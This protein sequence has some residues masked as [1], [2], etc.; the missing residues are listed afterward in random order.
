MAASPLGPGA[1]ASDVGD[2]AALATGAGADAP[3]FFFVGAVAGALVGFLTGAGASATGTGGGEATGASTVGGVAAGGVAT[4]GA[5]AGAAVVG[6]SVAGVV[7]P[8][9][10]GAG[11]AGDNDVGGSTAGVVDVDG[12][13]AGAVEAPV[14]GAGV[15]VGVAAGAAV[16]GLEEDLGGAAAG[17]VCAAALVDI[18]RQRSAAQRTA[19]RAIASGCA[20]PGRG[21]GN[22]NASGNEGWWNAAVG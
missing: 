4:A 19:A 1:S 9:A 12:A 21:N 20:V 8:A 5:G 18:R 3:F 16:V 11:V 15:T 10:T 2:W 13:A 6:L 17:D 7:G 22:R 14:G